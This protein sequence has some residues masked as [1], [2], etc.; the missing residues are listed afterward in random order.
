MGKA[1]QNKFT[2]SE[3]EIKRDGPNRDRSSKICPN[4]KTSE[5]VSRD[6]RK[7][8]NRKWFGARK[9]KVQIDCIHS[10]TKMS[11]CGV[12][13]VYSQKDHVY[14]YIYFIYTLERVLG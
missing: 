2:K 3:D 10:H 4:R 14:I 11:G 5:G 9:Q 13:R 12:I 8:V 1:A 6:D 7:K